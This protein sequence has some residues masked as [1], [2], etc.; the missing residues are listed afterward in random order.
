MIFSGKLIPF[1]PS[2]LDVDI[3]TQF[4]IGF[5]VALLIFSM[6]YPVNSWRFSQSALL[7]GISN[8]PF[9]HMIIIVWGSHSLT[10]ILP[11]SVATDFG[12]IGILIGKFNATGGIATAI[13]VADRLWGI[14]GLVF[15][16]LFFGWM[17]I[18]ITEFN[19]KLVISWACA[20]LLVLSTILFWLILQ[21][22]NWRIEILSNITMV[23]RNLTRAIF[24]DKSARVIIFTGIMNSV[25]FTAVLISISKVLNVE[26][27]VGMLFLISP[28][29]VVLGNLP[30]FYHGF[31][32][33]E[34]A[35]L[36]FSDPWISAS[37]EQ[38][39]TIS[40]LSGLVMWISATIGLIWIPFFPTLKSNLKAPA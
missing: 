4:I 32:G 17:H 6:S 11:T 3:N 15:V 35:I 39:I 2:Q 25:I 27:E 18:L 29:I 30:T 14:M 34:A 38:L 40:L 19:I 21:K 23:L 5:V 7:F 22:L 24:R 28:I 33:R 1:D 26:V 13:V 8:V 16:F 10:T 12:R 37:N 20:L 36:F 31:G 9:T